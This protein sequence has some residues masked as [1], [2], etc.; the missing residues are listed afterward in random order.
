MVRADRRALRLADRH[1]EREQPALLGRFHDH[2]VLDR[3]GR[4]DQSGRLL[5]VG[6]RRARRPAASIHLP[7]HRSAPV[8]LIGIRPPASE[9]RA[10]GQLAIDHQLADIARLHAVRHAHQAPG[11]VDPQAPERGGQT[12]KQHEENEGERD[13]LERQSR[14]HPQRRAQPRRSQSA[15]EFGQQRDQTQSDQSQ[16]EGE[17]EG[18]VEQEL[19]HAQKPEQDQHQTQVALGVE[20]QQLEHEHGRQQRRAAVLACDGVIGRQTVAQTGESQQGANPAVGQRRRPAQRH[21]PDGQDQG[22]ESRDLTVEI[23]RERGAGRRDQQR[24]P[25]DLMTLGPFVRWDAIGLACHGISL[26]H[27]RRVPVGSDSV[28]YG[29]RL[30][31]TPRPR[32]ADADRSASGR[33]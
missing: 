11:T 10:K 4:F 5:P 28:R 7:Q 6:R 15:I 25:E 8:E 2:F 21:Q 12:R 17:L 1:V 19:H 29:R 33:R 18:F 20:F 24:G 16:I 13:G 32:R 23:A 31:T 26:V 9:A 27:G 14:T 30:G 22:Q 3:V